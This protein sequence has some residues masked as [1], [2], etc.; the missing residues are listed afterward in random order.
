MLR[1]DR[2][3]AAVELRRFEESELSRVRPWFDHE[4]VRHRLGGPEWVERALR[5]RDETVPGEV[6][7]GLRVL[8]SHAWLAWEHEVPVGYLGG[9]VYDR[10]ARYDGS[11]PGSPVV[12]RV[13][14]GPAMSSAYVVDP[15]RWRRGLGVA[16]LRAW[17][18]L[19]ELGDV[20]VFAL[21][22]DDDNLAS[23]RCAEAAGFSADPPDA[24][25]EG[26]IQ[27]LWRRG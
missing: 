27:H 1:M 6:F 22:I 15:A 7:R 3:G 25:W 12:D 20:R 11:D 23:Q 19:P 8:G 17:V 4:E 26:T 5:L 24:D 16:M 10:W 9:D 13:E 2:D 18:A 21:G 14:A